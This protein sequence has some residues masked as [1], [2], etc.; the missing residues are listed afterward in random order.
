MAIRNSLGKNGG[1]RW[2]KFLV[3][4][5]DKRRVWVPNAAPGGSLPR[6]IHLVLS[7]IKPSILPKLTSGKEQE[8]RKVSQ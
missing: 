7:E 3:S 1:R 2:E 4:H 5:R 6:E 8:G